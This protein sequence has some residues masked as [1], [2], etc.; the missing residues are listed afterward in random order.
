MHSKQNTKFV[1][2]CFVILSGS[3][4]W[5]PCNLVVYPDDD[6]DSDQSMSVINNMR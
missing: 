3:H 2:T 6:R 5:T 4:G 1:E